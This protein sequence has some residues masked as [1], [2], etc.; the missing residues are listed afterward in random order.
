VDVPRLMVQMIPFTGVVGDKAWQA[1]TN[2][3]DVEL[4][5]VDFP[6]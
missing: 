2:S 6:Q 4:L 5:V 3:F 1:G